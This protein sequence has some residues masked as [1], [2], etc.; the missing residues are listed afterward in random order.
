MAF[1]RGAGFN[2]SSAP[3]PNLPGFRA[4]AP[5]QETRPKRN[6]AA[7]ARAQ[8]PP[9]WQAC[10][11]AL[12]HAHALP[13]RCGA[14]RGQRMCAVQLSSP[15][16]PLA[17]HSSEQAPPSA[18]PPRPADHLPRTQPNAYSCLPSAPWLASLA[19]PCDAAVF[20]WVQG[21]P[22]CVD[23]PSAAPFDSE[24]L[25]QPVHQLSADGLAPRY[26]A[27]VGQA[28]AQ[29]ALPRFVTADRQVLRFYAYFKEGVVE[30]VEENFR[31]R[32]CIIYYYIEDGSIHVGEPKEANS[33]IPQGVFLKRHRVPLHALGT[34]A[35]GPTLGAAPRGF[36]GT[37]QLVVG[38]S[39]ELY[40]RTFFIVSCDAWTREYLTCRGQS[41]AP[42]GEYPQAPL[43]AYLAKREKKV[44]PVQKGDYHSRFFTMDRKVLRFYVVWDD[45]KRLYGQKHKYVLNYYLSDD[46]AE[47]LE[48]YDPRSGRDP[49]P[50][51]LQRMRIPKQPK[52][53]GAG[54]VVD[55]S[56][57]NLR[58][59]PGAAFLNEADLML[60]ASIK[61]YARELFIYD[62]DPFTKE[63]LKATRAL[64]D[65]DLQPLD[66]FSRKTPL[67][68]NEIPPWN[69]FGG[70]EDSRQN[71]LSLQPK[72]RRTDFNKQMENLGK[73]LRYTAAMAATG[74]RE[75]SVV[76][77]GRVFI[78]TFYL[79]N[80]TMAIFEP[81]VKNSGLVGGKFLERQVVCHPGSITR[82][83]TPADLC[84]GATI[85]VYGRTF[86][87]L[88]ADV[89]S[90]RYMEERPET[91]PQSD[92]EE[93]V[94]KA[95]DAFGADEEGIR[96]AL[97]ESAGADG[98][99]RA[100]E[101][102][103]ALTAAGVGVTV[104]EALTLARRLDTAGTGS[105]SVAELVQLLSI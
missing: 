82:K 38:D 5:V 42:D 47:V 65:G 30:R 25:D 92:L 77:K 46:T 57:R 59:P 97:L 86:L 68:V 28:P 27:G 43:Q 9:P 76:D 22:L 40:G 23:E 1:Y 83:Y 49:F 41:V 100:A 14:S 19:L 6:G 71:C 85:G 50:K 7:G 104:Q 52:A 26:G 78:L 54:V 8:A 51:L 98:R 80:D 39:I 36:V 29:P 17:R 88:E 31:V 69:G 16:Q 74:G 11:L 79:E 81:P 61:I 58:G 84:V 15:S 2:K 103:A 91:F 56:G 95:K 87:L 94:D 33:G 53:S 99:L 96:S 67:A 70:E 60:G 55:E 21:I 66:V 63:Y 4:A 13:P 105:V 10:C 20:K 75:L 45:R 62:A 32:R 101:L 3:L 72:P 34:S 93:V 64:T 18:A 35:G 73:T 90:L 102:L 48:I 24:P 89:Y 12:L 37:R 44:T